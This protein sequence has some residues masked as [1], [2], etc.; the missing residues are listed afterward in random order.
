MFT[1][2]LTNPNSKL[3][4]DISNVWGKEIYFNHKKFIKCTEEESIVLYHSMN[5]S[6]LVFLIAQPNLIKQI[7]NI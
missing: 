3:F 6:K 4:K 5:L 1:K 7:A 2:L